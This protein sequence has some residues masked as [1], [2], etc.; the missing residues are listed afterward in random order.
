MGVILNLPYKS[1]LDPDA[2]LS[3]NDCGPAC[4]AMLINALGTPVTTDAV[5]QRTGSGPEHNITMAQLM[6]VS[7]SYE[8]PLDF[9]MGWGLSE[10]R[11]SLSRARPVIALVHYGVFSELDPDVSTQSDFKGPH[12]LVVAGY[13]DNNVIVHD[14]LWKGERR[15]EGAFRPWPN[16]VWLQAWGSCH[17]DCDAEGKCNPNFTVLASVKALPTTQRTVVAPDMVRRIRAKAALEGVPEPNL[18]D[19]SSLTSYALALGSWGRRVKAHK[20]KPTDTL[21]RLAKAYYGAGEKMNVIRNFNGLTP[22]DVIR[23]GQILLIPEPTHPGIIPPD[24]QPIGSTPAGPI[25]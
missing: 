24:R 5:F 21:W 11:A 17:L 15:Q 7:E 16:K 9:R 19:P 12:F 4:L 20:V 10:L 8:A 2:S 14:P 3:R 25:G 23:D 22:T 6:R 18:S 1:Q 13:N